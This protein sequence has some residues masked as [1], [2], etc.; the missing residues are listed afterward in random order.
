[1]ST[2]GEPVVA[3]QGA[4]TPQDA[5]ATAV[6]ARPTGTVTF[7]F[8]DIEGSTRLIQELGD[9]YPPVLARHREIIEGA[10]VAEG[11]TVFGT[12]GDAL[13]VAFGNAATAVTAAVKS[14]RL[15]ASEPWPDGRTLRVRMGIHTGDVNV[16]GNDYV[17]LALHQVARI[18]A[19]GNGGQVLVSNATRTL[20]SGALTG[21]I[22]LSDLGL[23]RL[24]DLALP[25]HLYQVDDAQRPET[26][27][28]VRTL[29]ARP[30]NLPVQ[31][32]SFVGRDELAEASRLLQGTHLLTL[33][34]PGGTGKTRLAL[35]LAADVMEAFPDGVFFI[36]LE[37][38]T[39]PALVPSAITAAIPASQAGTTPPLERLLAWIRDHRALLVLDNFEQVVDAATLV[40]Q[41]LREGPELRI[42]VTSR[43]P[44]HAYG[45][46]EFPVPAMPL[47]D[48]DDTSLERAARSEAVRL[49]VERAMAA[50]PTFR[51][52]EQNA[53]A[54][55]DIVRRLDGLPLAIELAAARVRLL[56]VETLRARLDKRLTLLV[57]GPR[58]RTGRQQT[59][60]GAID[61][62][63]DLLDAAD[64]RLFERFAVF[65]GGAWLSAAEKCCGPAEEVG[66]DVLDG[67]GSLADKSLLR[68]VPIPSDQPRFAMLATIREYAHEKL[69]AGGEDELLHR[70]H[71]ESYAELAETSAS[72]LTAKDS[73]DWLDRLDLDHDNLRSALDWAVAND[74]AAVAMRTA[75]A[76][77]RFWQIRG[78]LAEGAERLDRIFALPSA[79][80]QPPLLR[81]AAEG[82][83]GSIAYWRGDYPLTHR[84]YK[85]AL[86]AARDS[87]DQRT[88]AEALNNFAFAPV[89]GDNMVLGTK[90]GRP[91]LE[92]ALGL[93][94]NLGDNVGVAHV[95]WALAMA[96]IVE[97]DFA[98]ARSHLEESLRRNRAAADTFGIGWDLHMIGL[99]DATERQ[100]NAAAARFREGLDIFVASGDRGGILLLIAD[101]AVLA[102]HRGE[103]ERYWRLSGAV[104]AERLRTGTDL[105]LSPINELKWQVPDR[106]TDDSD[107]ARWWA[108][109]ERLSTEEAITLAL[110]DRD[111]AEVSA[112]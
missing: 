111:A 37:S 56:P 109:G 110:E 9:R 92:E 12:E 76:L 5:V 29:S 78:H 35:Q 42:V 26:F 19:A 91:Y 68:P 96:D 55:V 98:A 94:E 14:Q 31:L 79:Q 83:A 60:R 20:A 57:G 61:W 11:G 87:G 39:D 52:T 59:L 53:T 64:R 100:P 33:T 36:P 58:D 70:R 77:W 72:H 45:E 46:Q 80:A 32:T 8:T 81:A 41:L 104:N 47:P 44:L 34:G 103:T 102:S 108:E 51:L 2:E 38:I 84:H 27:P 67:V 4:D 1:V 88:L 6:P 86:E 30:N 63:Y 105:I 66:R 90:A 23:H 54:V 15:L 7:L 71:A 95:H 49:F 16:V 21:G 107:A 3:R 89:P 50:Q 22:S 24:K 40:S 74:E 75:S 25:E 48:A 62:S 112:G 106:P 82:A 43:V 73:R 65:A 18:S 85:A 93:Y 97:P 28:A 10:A 99:V 17:G 13:F 69:E 101:F